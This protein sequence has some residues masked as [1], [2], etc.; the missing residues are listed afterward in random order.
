M[1]DLSATHARHQGALLKKMMLANFHR[2][3]VFHATIAKSDPL[4]YT[5]DRRR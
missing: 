2:E 4:P 3:L 5:T 1:N